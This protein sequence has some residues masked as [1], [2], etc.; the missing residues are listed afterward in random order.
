MI[1]AYKSYIQEL[2]TSNHYKHYILYISNKTVTPK[3][4]GKRRHDIIRHLHPRYAASIIL[5]Y[6]IY[7]KNVFLVHSFCLNTYLYHY[8]NAHISVLQTA[9]TR[10]W[11]PE[12][13][14]HW[15]FVCPD[16][17]WL[18]E[19]GYQCPSVCPDILWLH[20]CGYQCLLSVQTSYDYMNV[21]IS[22]LL[23]V[24]TPV[25]LP[26]CTYQFF[27]LSTHLMTTRMH[28]SVFNC[29][30]THL[31]TIR[32]Y[33]SQCS[34]VFILHKSEHMLQIVGSVLRE[35][36]ASETLAKIGDEIIWVTCSIMTN[37][38]K[39]ASM[40]ILSLFAY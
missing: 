19:C 40:I 4:T 22:V 14:Y 33:M 7:M 35:S 34:F 26:E 18:H 37:L 9:C 21:V 29:L 1:H 10:V 24:Q 31:M 25:W 30:S 11:L 13:M 27:C 5:W 2:Q 17:L 23:S 20:E 8:L 12:C 3:I 16:T 38:A 36:D 6:F 32:R 39:W 28:T 15:P